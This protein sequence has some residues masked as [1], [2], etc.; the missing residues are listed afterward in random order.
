MCNSSLAPALRTAEKSPLSKHVTWLSHK[1]VRRQI[2]P[3]YFGRVLQS[4]IAIGV[5]TGDDEN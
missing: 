1:P 5:D 4:Y 3:V 2:I